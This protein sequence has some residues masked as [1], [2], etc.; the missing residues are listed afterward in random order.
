MLLVILSLYARVHT[1]S[2]QF[3]GSNNAQTL[4]GPRLYP[5]HDGPVA[6]LSELKGTGRIY[7]VQLGPHTAPYSLEDLAKWLHSKYSLDVQ[8]LPPT[9]FNSS[10]W[11]P[12]RRQYVA[13]LLYQ[14]IEHEHPDLAANPDAYLIGFTDADMYP[15]YHNW[16]STYAERDTLHRAAI[17][18]SDG[19]Q[20]FP[21]FGAKADAALR[22]QRLQAKLR[23]ILL[24][25][26]AI[27]YWHLPV[28]N[29]PTSV[30]HQP[31]DYDVPVDD[32]YQSDLDP[33]RTPWG[34]TEGP[35]C[36]FFAWSAKNGIQPL[37]GPLIRR[38][39]EVQDPLPD[40]SIELFIVD[41]EQGTVFSKHTDFYLPDVIP[42]RFQR[43]IGQQW[44]RPMSFG[45]CG[46]N[47]YDDYLW[48]RNDM[49]NI[50]VAHAGWGSGDMVRVKSAFFSSISRDKW[51]DSYSSGR[52]DEM[53]WSATPF[54]HFDLKRF[55]GQVETFLSCNHGTQCAE[56]GLRNPESGQIL[57]ERDN[58]RR[59]TRLTS[60]NKS[61]IS[62]TYTGPAMS[63]AQITDNR[64]YTVRYGYD[65]RGRLTSVTY[66]A[67][68]VLTYTY[69]DAQHLLTFSAAPNAKAAPR[70][71]MRNEYDQ[72]KLV[73]QTLASGKTYTYSY[74]PPAGGTPR[75]TTIYMPG[76]AVYDV[77]IRG[78]ASNIRERPSPLPPP[79]ENKAATKFPQKPARNA[80][81]E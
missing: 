4:R 70:L 32:I 59:L 58:L 38:C 52:I 31:L 71:L 37:A 42:I 68:Q 50:G 24:K 33:D 60:P 6:Q 46:S 76:G 39:G 2:H 16:P 62:L 73:K 23:R 12:S 28:N 44:N 47:N 11:N 51:V 69:D 10:D 64:G 1:R 34:R 19:L 3:A 8:I 25:N 74:A 5:H 57:F 13:E 30:L 61:W 54:E 78:G 66:P 49:Q 15:V 81:S 35:P 72:G 36:V 55:D 80:G 43:V 20:D 41:V 65:A 26:V 21:P 75:T 56:I 53:R 14:R 7:L 77:A 17:I 45:V 40:P 79:Q 22:A 63:V 18:S 67:G 29:D 27:L 48:S 9:A